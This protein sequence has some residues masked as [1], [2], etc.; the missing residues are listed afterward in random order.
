[1]GS[2]KILMHRGNSFVRH[3]TCNTQLNING[4]NFH[5]YT[6]NKMPNTKSDFVLLG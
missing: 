5:G 6:G 2:N 1:M 3:Y 4:M